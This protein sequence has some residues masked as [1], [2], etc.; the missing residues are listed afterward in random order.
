[1]A[2]D[3]KLKEKKGKKAAASRRG[4]SRIVRNYE[5]CIYLYYLKFGTT[6]TKPKSITVH[7]FFDPA[8]NILI[9]DK[10]RDLALS[11]YK[12]G[13]R[14]PTCYGDS[15]SDMV[16]RRKG[17]FVIVVED[18]RNR[19][20]SMLTFDD[21][22]DFDF[23]PEN[24]GKHTF[25][26]PKYMEVKTTS[27]N[28]QIAYCFN[29]MKSKKLSRYD[30]DLEVGERENF[31]YSLQFDNEKGA[32]YSDSGGTNLGPPV[33]PPVKEKRGQKGRARKASGD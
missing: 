17:Y 32:G 26:K 7:Y 4:G 15:F 16:R 12:L 5:P 27:V 14:D 11:I 31:G 10:I 20:L 28:L 24:F 23:K 8:S 19:K 6:G 22:I 9:E 29:R 18:E 30:K 13:V 21:R 25:E 3:A 2:K 1:M 33:P